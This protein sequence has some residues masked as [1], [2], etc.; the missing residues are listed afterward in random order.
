MANHVIDKVNA[1]LTATEQVTL[2]RLLEK[3][4]R[5]VEV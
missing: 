5:E 1:P 3:I 2:I 4:R